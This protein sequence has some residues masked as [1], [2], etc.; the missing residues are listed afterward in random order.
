[1]KKLNKDIYHFFSDINTFEKTTELI[2]SFELFKETLFSEFWDHLGNRIKEKIASPSWKVTIS[3]ADLYDYSYISIS[4]TK[5]KSESVVYYIYHSAREFCY[6]VWFDRE[7]Y[8]DHSIFLEN[9]QYF[10]DLG[11]KIGNS[12]S[13]MPI[14]YNITDF[15]IQKPEVY[16]KILPINVNH[17]VEELSQRLVDDFTPEIQDYIKSK[18]SQF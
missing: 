8:T 6:G 3:E 5:D 17:T 13:P 11:W 14:W 10:K 7:K 1:M 15:D 12:N 9:I 4:D 2:L 18:L 16:K